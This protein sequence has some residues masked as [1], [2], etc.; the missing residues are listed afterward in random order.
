MAPGTNVRALSGS[1]SRD[2]K[3]T[4]HQTQCKGRA[5]GK[6]N[7]RSDIP[8]RLPDGRDLGGAD[9]TVAAEHGDPQM[10]SRGGDDAV[11]HIGNPVAWDLEH[12]FGDL[13]SKCGLFEEMDWIGESGFQISKCSGKNTVLLREVNRL[14]EAY[15]RN[16]DPL[17]I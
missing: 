6:G 14:D 13:G 10:D 17:A 12:G 11:W 3:S 7:C 8:S 2:S 4:E 16:R 9:A 1:L 5:Q 15:R